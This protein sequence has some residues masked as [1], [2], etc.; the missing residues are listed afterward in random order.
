MSQPCPEQSERKP[1]LTRE[2]VLEA[3]KEV[4]DPEV[5][6]SI[7]AL[8]LLDEVDIA[9]GQVTVRFHL[10][11]PFCPAAFA[12]SIADDIKGRVSQLPGVAG[13]SVELLR[14]YSAEEINRR[15]NG[16]TSRVKTTRDVTPDV[17]TG[18]G[19]PAVLH[20]LMGES[21][22]ACAS[23]KLLMKRIE[24]ATRSEYRVRWS[25]QGVQLFSD[26]MGIPDLDWYIIRCKGGHADPDAAL[27]EFC[28][29]LR[30]RGHPIAAISG[31]CSGP[32]L[33]LLANGVSVA[34][35]FLSSGSSSDPVSIPFP[36]MSPRLRFSL[37]ALLSSDLDLSEL[38]RLRLED[39]GQWDGRRDLQPEATADP[40]AV[41]V[42]AEVAKD[43]RQRITFLSYDAQCAFLA[44]LADPSTMPRI[45]SAEARA[46]A[47]A[48]SPGGLLS[49]DEVRLVRRL[50]SSLVRVTNE[51]NVFLCLA[52]AGVLGAA[53][54]EGV[55]FQT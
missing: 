25:V 26:V 49:E 8:N 36:K 20:P 18:E 10:T 29:K 1:I 46:P 50:L 33:W 42:R 51:A 13:V 7:L 53:D 41:R 44:Y 11:T 48:E 6:L 34:H 21:L 32:K 28:E 17:R 5:R 55:V 19:S 9:N 23:V 15:V 43:G 31:L 12:S 39:F 52:T 24:R 47:L 16:A 38:M 35:R 27:A 54:I 22:L 14:H 30:Q 3:L 2:S 4:Q 45:G 37:L 40:L